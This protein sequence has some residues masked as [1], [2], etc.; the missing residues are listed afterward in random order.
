MNRTRR[1][2]LST[3]AIA[4]LASAAL[5]QHDS[6]PKAPSKPGQPTP[7]KPD[8]KPPPGMDN[9]DP[10]MKEMMEAYTQAAQPGK[11]HEWLQKS[12]GTWEGKVKSYEMP[13]QPPTEST[14]TTVITSMM[15]GRYTRGET[16]GEMD[17]MGQK[18]MFEGFGL[19]GFDNATQKFEQTW[20]DN[21]GT[22]ML[23]GT[24]ELSPD[25]KTLT[26]HLTCTNPATKEPMNLR[27]VETRTGE[28]AM[29]LEM[30]GV[31]PMDPAGKERKMMEIDFTR[32]GGATPHSSMKPK[33]DMHMTPAKK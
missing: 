3:F 7:A 25:G 23:R 15:D 2:V 30:Y 17:M 21:M 4:G 9:M 12:V 31:D 24:G 16:R 18:M 11:M 26:W 6:Q 32:R 33:S 1:F 13:D 22:G 28:N 20:V 10:K 19:Y 27:E 8:M 14:C 5:A 29:R